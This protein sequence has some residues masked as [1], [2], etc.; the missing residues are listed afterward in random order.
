M[1]SMIRL[2]PKIVRVITAAFASLLMI[3]LAAGCP[4]SGDKSGRQSGE[5]SHHPARGKANVK[6]RGAAELKKSGIITEPLKA[7]SF[8]KEIKV[9]G[10]VLDL[11]G[12]SALRG[13][14]ASAEARRKKALANL[15][16]SR[17]QF[18]RAKALNAEGKNIS[19][20]ALQAAQ[21]AM[22]ADEIEAGSG[23]DALRVVEDTVRRQWGDVILHWLV[24]RS[25]TMD[26][27]MRGE[28]LLV[29]V[30]ISPGTQIE[31][32][33]RKAR[34]LVGEQMNF[35][36]DL[37]SPSPR[38]DPHIQ[39]KSFFYIAPASK[40]GLLPGMNITAYL[41]SGPVYKGFFVPFSAVVW[42]QGRAWIFIQEGT[43][44]FVRHEIPTMVPAKGGII[45]TR[46]FQAGEKIVVQGAQQLLSEEFSREIQGGG[47][48]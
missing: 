33:P 29:L 14:Y 10:A 2:K 37:V 30:S 44:Y 22:Q 39:E 15:D 38:T 16:F 19:D 9:F 34:I 28:A 36:A 27:L 12:L 32:P 45:V 11:Q 25:R 42:L 40:T 18:E 21:S 6:T 7:S 13:E 48:D 31:E 24:G 5:A 47:D 1:R 17:L 46:G 35:T 23:L 41:Q 3:A 43:S 4:D 8:R 26:R 20:K